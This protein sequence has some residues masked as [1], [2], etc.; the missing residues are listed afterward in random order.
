MLA[1]FSKFGYTPI[2]LIGGATGL[3][4]DP[5]GKNIEREL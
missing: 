3:I 4:G 2:G 1:R 5:S